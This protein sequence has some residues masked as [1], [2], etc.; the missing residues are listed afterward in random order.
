MLVLGSGF[1]LVILWFVPE[2]LG[3]GDFLRAANRARQPNPDSAAFAAFPFLEVFNR[4]ASVLTC[5]VYVG[6]AIAV[7]IAAARPQQ[8]ASRWRWPRSPPC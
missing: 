6:G 7:V 1:A 3:S 8:E 4:S 2:Y 5:P